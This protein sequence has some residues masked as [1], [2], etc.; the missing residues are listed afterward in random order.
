MSRVIWTM[1][2]K[3]IDKESELEKIFK[4][5]NYI[6]QKKIKGI[7]AIMHI[8]PDGS[9]KFT[10]R[11]ASIDNPDVPIEITHRLQ[12]L[13]KHKIEDL[14]GVVL[15]CEM[16]SPDL[17]D[18]E[19]AGKLNYK[20]TVEVPTSIHPYFFDIICGINGSMLNEIPLGKRL[21]ILDAIIYILQSKNL[22]WVHSVPCVSTEKYKRMYLQELLQSGE[23]GMVF[24]NL[25]SKY[26]YTEKGSKSKKAGHW[27]KYK[28]KDTVDAI[29]TGATPPEQFYK[30]QSTGTYDTNRN[31]KPWLMGWFGSLN[32]EFE[33]K[34]GNKFTGSCSGITDEMK[35]LLSNGS[36]GVK[37]EYIGRTIEVEF[38]ERNKYGNCEHPR[39]IRL[40][41][42]I[43]K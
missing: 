7:R 36:W 12:H 43:E 18:S 30:D 23:E 14:A 16:W 33:D 21:I 10:T 8:L 42:E 37:Q 40:R 1:G 35:N 11:G 39:F 15:D 22:D 28:K 9:L 41:E 3:K 20:S 34:D 38:F 25:N 4:D 19:I 17:D 6:G 32:F 26:I 13:T 2:C 5:D 31:T 29:I 27:Y 24:K